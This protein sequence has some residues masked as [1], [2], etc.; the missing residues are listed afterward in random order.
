MNR[1]RAA[2]D[3]PS[4]CDVLSCSAVSKSFGGASVLDRVTLSFPGAGVAALVGPNGAGK[5]TLFNILTGFLRPDTGECCINGRQI[6]SLAPHEIAKLGV[7]RTFQEVRLIRQL[8]VVEN[9]SL[10]QPDQNG[11]R[12]FTALAP[13]GDRSQEIRNR[14]SAYALLERLQLDGVANGSAGDLSYGQQKLLSLGCCLA[15]RPNIMLLDEPLSGV[16]PTLALE[17]VELIADA[18]R[19]GTL[20]IFVEHDLEAVV[21]LAD[22]VIVLHHGAMLARGSPAEILKLP[23]V[24]EAYV[25]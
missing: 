23:E 25:G 10:A 24:V 17:I 5:T 13:R 7:G 9:L 18:G 20:V 15:M 8:S 22:E 11:E 6:A 16:H 12:I 4:R 14:Q 21:S 19:S 1:S 3:G 2:P